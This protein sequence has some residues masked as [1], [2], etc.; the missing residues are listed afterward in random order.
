MSQT[1]TLTAPDQTDFDAYVAVPEGD[2][3]GGLVLIHEIWGLVPHIR[4]VADRYAREGWLVVAP[5]I[6]SRAGVE[7]EA[8]G[9]LFALVN[10]PDEEKRVAAQPRMR[11]ALTAGYDP[12]YADWAVSALRSA[13]DWLENQPGVRGRVGVTGF[14]FGGSYAF[15]LAAHDDRVRGAVP[16]YGAAPDA[17]TID[18][19]QETAILAIYGQHDP[20]LIDALPRVKDDMQRAGIDFEA[21]V[22]PDAAH[23]FFND[24]GRRYRV[25]DAAD[26][27]RRANEFLRTRVAQR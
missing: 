17:R 19:L 8:G 11:E 27:W 23:A 15:L 21:V 2:P 12:A 20:K 1:I 3:I 13:V 7:P 25:D 9:E 26:A 22:Y 6:L 10:H 18:H 5:D 14:C 16:F 24:T 4:D